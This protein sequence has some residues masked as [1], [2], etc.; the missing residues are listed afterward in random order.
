MENRI[1]EITNPISTELSCLRT[2]LVGGL[3]DLVSKN[4]N[5]NINN[6]SVEI[7][8]IFH[9]IKPGEQKDHLMA[10][11]S[12]KAI[13]KNWIQDTRDYDIFDLKSDLF[14]VLKLLKLPSDNVKVSFD[15]APYFHPGKNGSVFLGK[16]K[17]QA[18]EKYILIF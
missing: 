9:G 8:P 18:M 6:I 14:S 17:L 4:N 11:R 3:L 15:K 7:G 5:K 16:K 12:G 13:E 1:V 2:N 10:L